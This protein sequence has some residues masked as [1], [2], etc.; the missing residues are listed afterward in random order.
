MFGEKFGLFA[1]GMPEMI[2]TPDLPVRSLLSGSRR[3]FNRGLAQNNED[4]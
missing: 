4:A 3:L 1:F 2:R